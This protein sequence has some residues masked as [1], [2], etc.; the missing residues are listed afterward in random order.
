[1]RAVVII[2]MSFVL[3]YYEGEVSLPVYDTVVIFWFSAFEFAFY[4][5]VR[6]SSSLFPLDTN[7]TLCVHG[8][9][10]GFTSKFISITSVKHTLFK[11]PPFP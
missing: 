11:R 2:I 10:T 3:F 7:P 6:S 9:N 4:D 8:L 5:I 1:M